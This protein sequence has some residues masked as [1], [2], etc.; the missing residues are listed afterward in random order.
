MFIAMPGH[1]NNIAPK[2]AQDENRD[3]SKL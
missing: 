3:P 2:G 1:Y